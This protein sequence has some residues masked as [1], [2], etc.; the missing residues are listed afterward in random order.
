MNI[1]Y[2]FLLIVF[3]VLAFSCMNNQEM[4][5][6]KEDVIGA[7]HSDGMV[8]KSLEDGETLNWEGG[9][10]LN[11]QRNGSYYRN[12]VS[13]N[14]ELEGD[15]I[16]LNPSPEL[17]VPSSR[18]RVIEYSVKSITLEMRGVELNFGDFDEFRSDEELIVTEIFNMAPGNLD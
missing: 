11:I 10:W 16:F 5:V 17:S 8:L 9:T 13:G 12:Y 18:Y 6:E 15:E 3:G 1:R 2:S 4:M 7:W 14:W